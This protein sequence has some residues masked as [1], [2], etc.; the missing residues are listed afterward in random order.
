MPEK[1]IRVIGVY[2]RCETEVKC[3]VDTT[4]AFPIEV[5]LH[6]GLALSPFLLAIIMDSLT[7]NC[8]KEA[9]WQMMFADGAVCK[10]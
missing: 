1:Y 4:K 6:Q 7:E 9:P 3:T 10:R 2:E 5:G 8:R